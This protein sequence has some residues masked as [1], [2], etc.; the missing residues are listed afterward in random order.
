VLL[1]AAALF[2][3]PAAVVVLRHSHAGRSQWCSYQ[4]GGG[5]D[6]DQASHFANHPH[7]RVLGRRVQCQ[8]R[9]NCA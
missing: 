3:A 6:G 2:T 9:L 7:K 5:Q 8:L 4:R 1:A